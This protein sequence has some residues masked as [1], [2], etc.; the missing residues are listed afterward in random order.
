M[1]VCSARTPARMHSR[2]DKGTHAPHASLTRTPT[3]TPLRAFTRTPMHVFLGGQTDSAL[4]IVW[5]CVL[6]EKG[7]GLHLQ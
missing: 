6:G 2:L 1:H 3:R 5:F 4:G 7:H